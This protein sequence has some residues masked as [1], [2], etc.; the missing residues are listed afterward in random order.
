MHLNQVT[1]LC[2][3]RSYPPNPANQ[4][5]ESNYGRLIHPDLVLLH[6]AWDVVDCTLAALVLAALW[7][8]G[9]GYIKLLITIMRQP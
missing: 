9:R 4:Q 3:G 2:D 6:C 5:R 7:N 8:T 1:V